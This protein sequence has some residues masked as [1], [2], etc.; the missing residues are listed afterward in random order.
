MLVLSLGIFVCFF[1]LCL[2]L[3][4]GWGEE[5]SLSGFGIAVASVFGR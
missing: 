1:W 4:L 2:S 5:G 3:I